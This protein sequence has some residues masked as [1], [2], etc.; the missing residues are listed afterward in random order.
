MLGRNGKIIIER[1]TG[2]V[3]FGKSEYNLSGRRQLLTLLCLVVERPRPD[4]ELYQAMWGGEMDRARGHQLRLQTAVARLRKAT[5]PGIF[6][7]RGRGWAAHGEQG[8]Y[9][10]PKNFEA[11][12]V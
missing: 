4:A 5:W 9:S 11:F 7:S 12:L 1:A 3:R 10:I 2:R 6:A 8:Q